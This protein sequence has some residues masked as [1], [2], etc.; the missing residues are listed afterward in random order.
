MIRMLN[1]AFIAVTGLMCLGLY[2]IAEQAR[3]AQADLS[4]TRVAIAQ[5]QNAL[6]VLGAEWAR[7]TQPARIQALAQR[8]LQISDLPTVE[9][10]CLTSLPDRAA[11]PDSPI[12]SA[13][14]TIA[15]PVA[16]PRPASM[17]LQPGT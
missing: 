7:V 1:F 5:E 6:T 15:V 4:A 10:G 13:N 3:I 11:P 14:V 12:R 17:I 8:H 9:L 16:R 2:R